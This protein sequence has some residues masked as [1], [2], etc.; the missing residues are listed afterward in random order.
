MKGLSIFLCLLTA[1]SVSASSAEENQQQMQFRGTL[2]VP[3]Q[4]SVN[5]GQ[6]IDVDFG[7]RVGIKKVDGK[8][9]LQTVN[10]DIQCDPGGRGLDMGLTVNANA[11]AYDGS[12]IQTD[13]ADLGIRLLQN[14]RPLALNQRM[15]IEA[16]NPPR[17]QAVPVSRPGAALKASAFRATATLLVDYQ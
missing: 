16:A 9:Y 2:N 10:Y 1:F 7:L 5:N 15:V 6:M 14:G 13:L 8:N 4:C 3:P 17:L 12:V 11:A